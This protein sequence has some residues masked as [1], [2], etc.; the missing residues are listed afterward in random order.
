MTRSGTEDR[1]A[2]SA[3]LSRRDEKAFDSLYG[4]HTPKLYGLS[5]RLTGGDEVEAAEVVQEVWA[6]AIP[7][8][9]DFRW[10]SSLSTWLCGIA[11]NRWREIRRRTGK[12][13][14]WDPALDE[15]LEGRPRS[16]GTRIDVTRAVDAL[17][18][19]YRTVLVLFGVYGYSHDEIAG[20]LGITTGTSKSQLS[21]A[22]TALRQALA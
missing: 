21:R 9:G 16:P 20:L 7:K 14:S 5:L 10:E 15:V 22:R 2:V 18:L 4:R 12:E 6:R 17:P 3:F 1:D 13:W 19:G 8:L 11:V